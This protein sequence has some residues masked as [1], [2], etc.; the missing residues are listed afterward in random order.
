MSFGRVQM[1]FKVEI[2]EFILFQNVFSFVLQQTV[3]RYIQLQSQLFLFSVLQNSKT[4][5]VTL[6]VNRK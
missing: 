1:N 5:T 4:E 3:K 2:L 6:P